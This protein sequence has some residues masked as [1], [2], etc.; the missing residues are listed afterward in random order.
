MTKGITSSLLAIVA[1]LALVCLAA[2][3]AFAQGRGGAGRSGDSD[4]AAGGSALKGGPVARTPDGKPDLTGFWNADTR[5]AFPPNNLEEHPPSFL[6]PG[7][8]SA[9]V[10]PPDGTIPYHAWAVKERDWRRRPQNSW[11]DPEGHCFLSGTPRQM[12]VMPYQIIQTKDAVVILYEYIHAVRIIHLD[13]RKHLTDKIRLWQGDSIGHWEGNTLVVDTTNNNGKTW[14]DL[15]GNLRSSAA[16]VVERLTPV[17]SDTIRYTAT[18]TDPMVFT[19]PWTMG[20]DI[21]RLGET[22]VLESACHEDERD[23]EHLRAVAGKTTGQ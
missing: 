20:F 5:G 19:R 18:I 14:F 9:V 4:V 22:E 23:Q 13:D 11:L 6:R 2:P 3:P 21:A 17:D 16:V 15:S 7:G 1:V 10:D 12:Y 8:R